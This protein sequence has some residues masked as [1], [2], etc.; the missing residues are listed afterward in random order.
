MDP[1]PEGPK[2][3][4]SRGSGGSGFGYGTLAYLNLEPHDVTAS[5]SAHQPSPHILLLGVQLAHVARVLV[6]VNHLFAA[7]KNQIRYK[8]NM[9]GKTVTGTPQNTE[10]TNVSNLSN[11]LHFGMDIDLWISILEIRILIRLRI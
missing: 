10:S 4:G 2:T 5:G 7:H 9:I 6:V 11:L 3:G 1:D 8:R